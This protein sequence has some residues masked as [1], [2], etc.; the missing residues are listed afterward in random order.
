MLDSEVGKFG[1]A[2]D[3]IFDTGEFMIKPLPNLLSNLKSFSGITV[4]GDG[5]I[6]FILEV[7]YLANQEELMQ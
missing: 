5:S 4:L 1:L 3:S 6:V 7:D 2:V